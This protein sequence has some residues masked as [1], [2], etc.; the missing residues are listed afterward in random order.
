MNLRPRYSKT[1]YKLTS[2]ESS[3]IQPVIP[4]LKSFDYDVW[5][6]I[7]DFVDPYLIHL[8]LKPPLSASPSSTNMIPLLPIQLLISWNNLD[9]FEEFKK[10]V[11]SYNFRKT[12]ADKVARFGNYQTML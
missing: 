7:Y 6:R 11:L 5:K 8:M 10:V 4:R 9:K 3:A 12:L 1:P 2:S